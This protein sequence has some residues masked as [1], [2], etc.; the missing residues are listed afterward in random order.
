MLGCRDLLVVVD[1]KMAAVEVDAAATSASSD[2]LPNAIA[3]PE[4]HRGQ[5]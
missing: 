5:R 1:L 2:N 3:Q 4:K